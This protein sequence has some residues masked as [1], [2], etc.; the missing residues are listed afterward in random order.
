MPQRGRRFLD[1]VIFKVRLEA[2]VGFNSPFLC[3]FVFWGVAAA[4]IIQHSGASV[5]RSVLFGLVP[6]N[7]Q[8]LVVLKSTTLAKV[9]QD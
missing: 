9:S 2:F 6:P 4:Q 5:V 8:R 7:E 3:F 1:V